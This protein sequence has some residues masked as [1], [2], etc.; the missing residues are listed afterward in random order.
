MLDQLLGMKS[1]AAKWLVLGGKQGFLV[2]CRYWE[3]FPTA[4]SRMGSAQH[5][6]KNRIRN[7]GNLRKPEREDVCLR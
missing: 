1:A 7:V 4:G 5:L 3:M 6:L 2:R